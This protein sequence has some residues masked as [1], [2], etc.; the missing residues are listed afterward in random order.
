[1]SD[2]TTSSGTQG[3]QDSSRVGRKALIPLAPAPTIDADGRPVGEVARLFEDWLTVRQASN[4]IGSRRT[5]DGYRDDMARWATLLADGEPAWDRLRLEHLTSD[6]LV[7]ALAAMNRAGL[8]VPA[9][10]RAMAPMRGL[11][12]WCV[13]SGHLVVDPT[14]IDDL[15][16]RSTPT[17]L[18]SHF[19][20]DELAR[21]VAA[22]TAGL[23]SQRAALRWPERDLAA[24]ALLSGAGLRA[25]ELC[26]LTW[27]SL[28]DLDRDE[29]AVR[30]HGKGSRE[31]VIPLGPRTAATIRA[32]RNQRRSRSSG[33]LTDR[34]SH[35]VIVTVHGAAVTPSMLNG[36][37]DHWLHAAAVAPRPGAK[38][39]AF[40][41]TAAD[42][43]LANGATLAEVQALLGHANIATTGVYTKVRSETLAGVVKAGRFELTA[44]T[45]IETT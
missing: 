33:S 8:S 4:R 42:G 29:P 39:H 10:Q 9:R 16:I 22:V 34:P 15:E 31:R 38:A 27:A 5:V 40:R 18:P 43:W 6:R 26:E 7:A 13:R 20:D 21:I 30:V 3:A 17:R 19:T 14:D 12:R 11:C 35:P 2:E 23:D 36:W 24:L 45:V 32:Y 25:S 41:H 37:I 44:S 28:V 1:M